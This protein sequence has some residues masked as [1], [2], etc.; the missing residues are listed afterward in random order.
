MDTSLAANWVKFLPPYLVF[1][2]SAESPPK[3]LHGTPGAIAIEPLELQG[4]GFLTWEQ[5]ANCGR[6][7]PVSAKTA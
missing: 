7:F 4:A 1:T 6:S 5:N 3:R 2:G